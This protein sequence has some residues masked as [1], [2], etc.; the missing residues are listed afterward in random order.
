MATS[1]KKPR[2]RIRK[3]R[4]PSDAVRYREHL[5]TLDLNQQEA[6][7]FLDVTER[8]SRRWANGEGD[9][10][11]TTAL[12]LAFMI[13]YRIKPQRALALLEEKS[14]TYPGHLAALGL[15]LQQAADFLDV[16][17]RTSRHWESGETR[18]PRT[19][20]LVLAFMIKHKTTTEQALALLEE[21]WR[22]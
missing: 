18:V 11:R 15:N 14:C 4:R 7:D 2:K 3:G 20:V 17:E 9:V 16:T 10:P 8:T 21:S 13:K 19:T 1:K 12:V 5:A 6:A 22:A